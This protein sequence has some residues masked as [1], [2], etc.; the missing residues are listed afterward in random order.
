MNNNN[1]TDEYIK[2]SLQK[3]LLDFTSYITEKIQIISPKV[4][5]LI[6][7]IQNAVNSS[8]GKEYEVKLYGSHATG[9]CLPWSDIDVVLCKKNGEGIEN[10]SYLPLQEL[11]TF[12]Q[13]QKI[14]LNL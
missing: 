1:Y 13:K 4:K 7:Y 2:K 3:D 11:Y 10:N 5:E 12:L 6:N 14:F 9:L 8:I